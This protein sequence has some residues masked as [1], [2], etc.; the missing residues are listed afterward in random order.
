MIFGAFVIDRRGNVRIDA[1]AVNVETSL[2]EHVE[3]VSDDADNLLR[4]VQRLGRQLS[5]RMRLPAPAGER[6]ATR[7]LEDAKRGQMLANLQFARALMEEDQRNS[8]KALQ[9]YREFLAKSPADY[10]PNQRREAEARIRAL[11]SSGSD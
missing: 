7:P 2:V 11:A 8:E 3:T 10:A 1:R 5:E 4:A 9:F 6:P